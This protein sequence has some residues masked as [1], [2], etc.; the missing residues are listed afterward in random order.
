MQAVEEHTKGI[1]EALT[2]MTKY[3]QFEI[4]LASTSSSLLDAG[5][6]DANQIM[7][8]SVLAAEVSFLTELN[9]RAER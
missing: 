2:N 9:R 6:R 8:N 7:L 5:K 1:L 4:N 3:L